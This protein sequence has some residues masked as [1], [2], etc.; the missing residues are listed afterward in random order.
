MS[1]VA[2]SPILTTATPAA[3][4]GTGADAAPG[5]ILSHVR[6]APETRTP[7][8]APSTRAAL[9][10]LLPPSPVHGYGYG[11]G[12]GCLILY[13][14]VLNTWRRTGARYR[15]PHYGRLGRYLRLQCHA[16]FGHF[17]RGLAYGSGLGLAGAIAYGVRLLW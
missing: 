3:P 2:G 13:C 17:L 7:E 4:E 5:A 12:Y 15:E 14:R 10:V 9:R 16:A 1:T 11:Y 6:V 8:T